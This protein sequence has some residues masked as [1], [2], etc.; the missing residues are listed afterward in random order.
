MLSLCAFLCCSASLR[1]P[2]LAALQGPRANQP[3]AAAH[4]EAKPREEKRS[5]GGAQQR[6]CS[7][8]GVGRGAGA[9]PQP[10]LR[11]EHLVPMFD[12]LVGVR[13]GGRRDGGGRRRRDA[14]GAG[15][16]CTR[17]SSIELPPRSHRFCREKTFGGAAA[18]AAG[19][20]PV[21]V[22]HC[23]PC[24]D[25]R[26]DRSLAGDRGHRRRQLRHGLVK[27]LDA[28]AADGRA[29][30]PPRPAPPPAPSCLAVGVATRRLPPLP[31]ASASLRFL[32]EADTARAR[33]GGAASIGFAAA[34]PPL[35]RRAHAAAGRRRAAR[36]RLE[37]PSSRSSRR[38]GASRRGEPSSSGYGMGGMIG[39]SDSGAT[40]G[41]EH[42]PSGGGSLARLQSS[43]ATFLESVRDLVK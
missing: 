40:T 22:H 26:G 43:R 41:S 19:A 9:R 5:P 32:Q 21:G 15:H 30:A 6:L 2:V 24:G 34:G 31:R 3:A 16:A 27:R 20:A 25:A 1:F 13:R 23:R 18:D 33:G 39:G 36:R 35:L 10:P 42:E 11:S 12:A 14:R 4:A 28:A 29:S 17:L 8:F 7:G 37:R 38:R